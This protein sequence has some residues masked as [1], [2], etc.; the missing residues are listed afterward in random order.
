MQ[1][2]SA[3][4]GLSVLVVALFALSAVRLVTTPAVDRSLSVPEQLMQPES[5]VYADDSGG[6]LHLYRQKYTAKIHFGTRCMREQL[7]SRVQDAGRTQY[8]INDSPKMNETIHAIG[9]ERFKK[10]GTAASAHFKFDVLQ[11]LPFNSEAVLKIN[12]DFGSEPEV[13]R[14]VQLQP[15]GSIQGG[16]FVGAVAIT[17]LSNTPFST[18]PNAFPIRLSWRFVDLAD[19][20]SKPTWLARQDLHLLLAPNIVYEVPVAISL[21]EKAGDYALEFSLVQEGHAWF[22]DRGMKIPRLNLRVSR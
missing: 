7:I 19:P 20:A 10:I 22:H 8:F 14:N 13:V 11:L 9:I 4:V 18:T 21:P 12:C 1:G 6:A 2:R 3:W 16:Q 17:N 15:Q 5:I